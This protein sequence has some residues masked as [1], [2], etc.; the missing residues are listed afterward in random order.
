MDNT[1]I[2]I[3]AL[4]EL[5]YKNLLESEDFNTH[6]HFVWRNAPH[7]ICASLT[8]NLERFDDELR[9]EVPKGWKLIDRRKRK[10]I[11]LNGELHYHRRIYLDEI[12]CRRYLLDEVLGIASYQRLDAAAFCWI[13]KTAANISFKKTARAFEEMTRARITRQTVMRCVHKAGELL[14][15]QEKNCKD[16][17]IS[18]PVLFFE[19]DG[20]W[21]DLQSETK[22]KPHSRHTY[23]AQYFKKSM[24]MKVGVIYAGKKMHRRLSA[25]HWCSKSSPEDFFSEGM[26]LAKNYYDLEETDYLSVASDAASWCKNH[27]LDAQVYGSSVVIST[28]DVYH[29]NQRVYKAFTTED[30]RSYF[31]NLLYKKDYQGFLQA[32]KD[33]MEAKPDERIEKRE[34]LYSYIKNNLDWLSSPSLTRTIRERLLGELPCMF[35]DRSFYDHL[36][37]LLSK[38]RYK[39]FL[40]DLRHIVAN[41]AD[42][43]Y[44]DYS[45]FLLDAEEAVRLIKLYGPMG[46][47]TMEGT[48]AKVYAARLKVWGCTWSK[49]GALAMMRVRAAIASGIELVAP[50]YRGWLN[51]KEKAKREDHYAKSTSDRSTFSGNGYLPPQAKIALTTHMAPSLYGTLVSS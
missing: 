40:R 10:L 25:F 26:S 39:R 14:G 19:F 15:E 22:S 24:E 41:C 33:R 9:S 34:D 42:K 29:V 3:D 30:D 35:S 13:V 11:T 50:G 51:E 4:S 32:L 7:L 45:T 16:S 49:R 2:C 8:K 18:T 6:L 43:L 48:N 46:L 31:L 12:G 38:R 20:I 37:T 23:K 28:L 21:I 1:T 44:Y 36:Y 27:G 5:F 47:G 17:K